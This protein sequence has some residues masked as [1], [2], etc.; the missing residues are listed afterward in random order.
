MPRTY[1][2]RRWADVAG[3]RT[4]SRCRK[5]LPESSFSRRAVN[6]GG[7]SYTCKVCMYAAWKK[8]ARKRLLH[9]IRN[10]LCIKC[11]KAPS[12]NRKFCESCANTQAARMRYLRANCIQPGH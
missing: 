11:G 4:C 1:V 5:L 7:L 12:T 8:S 10:L 9:R 6:K 2:R 3:H